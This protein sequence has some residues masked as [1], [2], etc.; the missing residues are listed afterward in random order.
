MLNALVLRFLETPQKPQLVRLLFANFIELFKRN[1]LVES[2]DL[3]PLLSLANIW[4]RSEPELIET[5]IR[6]ER[7]A[8]MITSAQESLDEP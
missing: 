7:L 4:R 3:P 5:T 2:V 8:E 6:A 1:K